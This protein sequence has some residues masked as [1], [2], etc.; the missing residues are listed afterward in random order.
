MIFLKKIATC[1]IVMII[2][3]LLCHSAL[4]EEKTK[5]GVMKFEVAKNL[6]P[7]LS[8]FF[9]EML[10]ERMVASGKFTV[11]DWEEI[12]RLLK[13]IAGSQPNIS[14]EDARRQAANQ[15]G[16]EK[17]YVGS[18]IKVA[19]K[20]H[21]SVKVLNLDLSVSRVIRESAGRED[22]F[23]ALMNR[24]AAK[25]VMSPEEFAKTKTD[26]AP[27]TV[28]AEEAGRLYIKT[29]PPDAR[30]RILNIKPP[31]RDGIDLE[32]GDYHVEVSKAGFKT[33]RKW[34]RVSA[35][36][37]T[38]D[39]LRLR[40]IPSRSDASGAKG[41]A[42]T[43]DTWRDA[44]TGME[45]VMIPAGSFM[46]GSKVSAFEMASRY[47]GKEDWYDGE[48]PQHQVIISKP[49][50]MQTC[51]ITVGQWRLF[52][53]STRY[54]TEVETRGGAVI[55]KGKEWKKEGGYFWGNPGFQQTENHPVTCVSWNDAQAFITWRNSKGGGKYRLPTEAEWEYACRA[56]SS[57]AFF[58]GDDS[59]NLDLYGWYWDNAGKRT[60]P[61]GAKRPNNWGLYD[62]HGNVWEWCQDWYGAYSIGQKIDPNGPLRG[63]DRVTRGGSYGNEPFAARSSSRAAVDPIKGSVLLGFRL[64]MIP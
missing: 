41:D 18:L 45:F 14:E 27:Q 12:D 4:C 60:H 47:G 40:E 63:S 33:E 43:G 39:E 56:G 38:V 6:D 26:E 20:Y 25:L 5:I 51:E 50:Y 53:E 11:V 21:A 24:V 55:W 36:R 32:P 15:L 35:E 49:F 17:M 34:I 13:Y 23:D 30:V 46:M 61:V 19:S 52:I 62:M 59:V 28:D 64:V 54:K 22:E 31:Y 37:D 48:Q 3:L 1:F 10:L 16:I 58:F 8:S 7:A 9:Y 42:K 29:I 57:G 44:F 2:L